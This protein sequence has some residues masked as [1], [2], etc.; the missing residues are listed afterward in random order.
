MGDQALVQ[1]AESTLHDLQP[2][3]PTP[4]SARN[5]YLAAAKS[6]DAAVKVSEEAKAKFTL[7]QQEADRLREEWESA[8]EAASHAEAVRLQ[9]L[10]AL[11]AAEAQTTQAGSAGGTDGLT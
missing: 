6:A 5:Q 8:A 4:P 10:E 3:E 7:A 1:Q 2:P 11:N 9:A